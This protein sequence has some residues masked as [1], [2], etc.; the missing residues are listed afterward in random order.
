MQ[1]AVQLDEKLLEQLLQDHLQL[2]LPDL[3][4]LNLRCAYKDGK[5]VIL[6]QHP[7]EAIPDKQSVFSLLERAV[8]AE[9]LSAIAQAQMYLR[10]EGEKRPYATQTFSLDVPVGEAAEKNFGWTKFPPMPETI[11]EETT[12]EIPEV[13]PAEETFPEEQEDATALPWRAWLPAVVGSISIVGILCLGS[14]YVMT[15]PCTSGTCKEISNAQQLSKNSAQNLQ[16]PKSGQDILKARQQLQ[17]AIHNLQSIPFWSSQH[18]NAQQMLKT[19][20]VQANALEEVLKGLGKA[21]QA[22]QKSQNPPHSEAEWLEIQKLWQEAIAQLQKTSQSSSAYPLAQQKLKAYKGYLVVVNQRL[23]AEQ[24]AKK[25]LVS[26]QSA[27][28]IAETRQGIA[29]SLESWQLVETTWETAMKELQKIRPGTTA[30]QDAQQL[31]NAYKPKLN[32]VRDRQVQEK[33]G[34]NA[35]NQSLQIAQ[36]AQNFGTNNQW[37]Q[38]TGSW[39][40]ALSYVKQVPKGT[41][42]YGQA[43]VLVTSYADALKQ[44]EGKLQIFTALQQASKDLDKVCAGTPKVCSY[45]I[46]TSEI[47]V[48]LTPAYAQKVKQT[49]LEAQGK[50][51]YKTQVGV[52]SHVYS[53]GESFGAVSDNARIRME[54]YGPDGVLVE[55]HE[56]KI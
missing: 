47:K 46:T 1:T 32:E 6:V 11:G 10:A 52:V 49:A 8:R 36:Q 56:P 7:I 34:A 3:S 25:Q 20:Q 9:N 29:Q 33:F 12:D 42:Y 30:Y 14:L 23:T 19:Y 27:A 28:K 5:L 51:D 45:T 13:V 31:I 39:R 44:A 16:R 22:S 24:Q 43:Q 40:N 53:L 17:E 15:S 35:Y 41:Y 18:Q 38:A 54:I 55:T 37:G 50:G 21:E 48:Y 2:E 26:A 4:A